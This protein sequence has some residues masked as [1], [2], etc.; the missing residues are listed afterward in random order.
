MLETV[1][2]INPHVRPGLQVKFHEVPQSGLDFVFNPASG[3][4]NGVLFDLL[5]DFPVYE[6]IV[7]LETNEKTVQIKGE[8]KGELQLVCS[9]CAEDFTHVFE[10]TFVTLFY[11][12]EQSIKNFGWDA[13]ELEGSFDLEF[14]EGEIIS[15]GE[16]IH[17]QVALEI[18]FKPMHSAKCKGLCVHCG[19]NFNLGSCECKPLEKKLDIGEP[20]ASPF[21]KLKILS[22]GEK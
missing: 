9:L 4:L 10:K 11:K 6:A 3:E 17:E 19:T 12:S 18:P 20:K 14:L 16:V 13:H 8:L 21:E 1:K 2:R 5:G 15:I 7:H 22:T